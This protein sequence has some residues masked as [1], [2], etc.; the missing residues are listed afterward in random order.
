MIGNIGKLYLQL[1]EVQIVSL[2]MFP[3]GI[4]PDKYGFRGSELKDPRNDARILVLFERLFADEGRGG[5]V[6]LHIDGVFVVEKVVRGRAV[7]GNWFQSP[8]HRTPQATIDCT[9]W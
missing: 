9:S 4:D 8:R 7:S 6:G 3:D 2:G 1:S 5:G